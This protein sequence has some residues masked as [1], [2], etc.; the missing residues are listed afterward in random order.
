M[1]AAGV[2]LLG[3]TREAFWVDE[4]STFNLT[5]H[6][7]LA[8]LKVF[9]EDVHP[10]AYYWGLAQWRAALGASE[11]VIRGYSVVW[12]LVGILA[13]LGFACEVGRHRKVALWA[14]CLAAVS[15][16]SVYFA[17]EAR[18]YAQASALV[19]FSSWALLAWLNR[20]EEGRRTAGWAILYVVSVAALLLTHYVGV[21]IALA[22]GMAVI[23]VCVIRRDLRFLLGYSA[24]AVAV[25]LLFLPWLWFVHTLRPSLYRASSLAWMPSP[26]WRDIW[27]MMTRDLVWGRPGWEGAEWIVPQGVSVLLLA[28]V[29]WVLW[30]GRSR[31]DGA[32]RWALLPRGQ[33]FAIWMVVGP[34][35]V[36]LAISRLYHPVLWYPRFSILVLPP[37][38]VL[39]A[40]AI[41]TVRRR[42]GGAVL[43]AALVII[44][45][46]GLGVQYRALTKAGMRNFAWFWQTEGPP[47]VVCFFP[48][49][50]RTAARY[51]V[52]PSLPR[53]YR[54]RLERRLKGRG[55]F[56]LW[57]CS[58]GNYDSII[59]PE[60]ERAERNR[61]LSLG[62]RRDL[63]SVDRLKIVEVR[64]APRTT[65]GK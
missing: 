59:R 14:V 53:R 62:I 3:L 9:A 19:A 65:A 43:P 2:R 1:L 42:A 31:V 64:V 35:L 30:S 6:P 57:V 22:Q 17:Q 12:S 56:T 54:Q 34:V 37:A 20:V 23:A 29:L 48:D 16:L 15:P 26:G 51:Q 60:R 52:G 5:G 27:L 47:D 24:G 32:P 61:V 13:T 36:A 11:Y 38:I 45:I 39:A 41:D 40:C 50:K 55:P 4:V 46:I 44:A 49:W 28:V 18:M 10:F 8:S 63:G 58:T 25:A 33:S 7:G 21:V